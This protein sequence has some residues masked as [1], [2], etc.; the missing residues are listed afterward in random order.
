MTGTADVVV[1]GGG[2]AG[3]ATAYHLSRRGVRVV[4]CDRREIGAEQ[5][6]R[7]WGFVQQQGRSWT[8][9]PLMVESNKMWRTLERDLGA[10]LDWVQGGHL[11]PAADATR[12]A[13]LRQ[14][15]E[16]VPRVGLDTRLLSGEE[17]ADL[18]P[19]MAGRFVGGLYTA[20]DGH[21][22]PVKTTAAFCRASIAHGASVLTDCPVE[23][24]T[25]SAGT[26]T[27]VT[28]S[29][30]KIRT[31]RVVC[32]AGGWSAG[33]LR[34]LGLDL[35]RR[36]VRAT[37]AR[38]TP[39]PAVT[40]VAVWGPTLAFRQRSDG[41][42]DLGAQ[43][44]DYD[45]TLEWFRHP[46]GWLRKY[47]RERKD[48]G[49]HIGAPLFRDLMALAPWSRARRRP[50]AYDPK[51][52]PRPNPS[53]A[54][55]SLGELHRLFPMLNGLTLERSWAGYMDATPDSLPVLG[56]APRPRGLVLATGF[57]GH[58]FSLG[59][60]VGRL[61]AEL[62]VD[63]RASLDLHAFRFSRFEGMGGR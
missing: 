18:I 51:A 12:L 31:T 27:G 34:P 6:G 40:P 24:I 7:N 63:R 21:V 4:L 11:I 54:S 59:P 36:L 56:D 16:V 9:V 38:T 22:D 45:I 47:L 30:G 8:E 53:R 5:S 32:A 35:P 41:R 19:S 58:G 20:S 17:V 25:A 48:A 37:V 28:T 55:R 33:L 57:S 15:L 23:S 26:I 39:G 46:R 1:I 50:F 29:R 3:C 49:V 60:I 52:E 42:F 14:W 61:M 43:G 10:D 13:A 44:M 2:I 62:I